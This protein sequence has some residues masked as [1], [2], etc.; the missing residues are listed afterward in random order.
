MISL[1][2]MAAVFRSIGTSSAVLMISK[3]K[4][5]LGQASMVS[6]FRSLARMKYLVGGTNER[7][8]N[9]LGLRKTSALQITTRSA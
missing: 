6:L 8:A 5:S 1:Q 3:L 2:E 4:G 7:V 9:P